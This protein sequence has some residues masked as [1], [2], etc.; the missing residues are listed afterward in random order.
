MKI[1]VKVQNQKADQKQKIP[2]KHF[3]GFNYSK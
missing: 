3:L 2:K 1:L